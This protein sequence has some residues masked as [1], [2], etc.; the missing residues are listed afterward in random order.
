LFRVVAGPRRSDA[1]LGSSRQTHHAVFIGTDNATGTASVCCNAAGRSRTAWRAPSFGV[2]GVLA[3]SMGVARR[4]CACERR[5][6]ECEPRLA[7]RE[8]PG[9][10]ELGEGLESLDRDFQL[11]GGGI[12]AIAGP[13]AATTRFRLKP[14][15]SPG[16]GIALV[17]KASRSRLLRKTWRISKVPSALLPQLILSATCSS[18]IAL[19]IWARTDWWCGAACVPVPMEASD[20]CNR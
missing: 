10:A 20:S 8:M 4:R 7:S 11:C 17:R 5:E 3:R 13:V 2:H 14:V 19:L 9:V 18:R 12:A 1:N 6:C 16:A 15:E